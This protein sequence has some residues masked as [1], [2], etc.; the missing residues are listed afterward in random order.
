MNGVDAVVIGAGPNGLV[1]ANLLADAGWS[2]VVLEGQN[3]PGGSVRTAEVTAPGFRNDL[4][5]SFF[6]LSACPSPIAFLGLE[7]FGL[8]WLRSPT[9]LTHLTPDNASVT[10]AT[11]LAATE[12]SLDRFADGDGRRW[13][14]VVSAWSRIEPDFLRV[15]FTPFPP[16]RPAVRLVRTTGVGDAL[17]LARQMLLPAA[18]L[19]RQ[20]FAGQGA[21]L[22]V[23]GLALHTDVPPTSTASGGFGLLMAMLAQRYGFPVPE[24][25][26]GSLTRALVTRLRR[27]GGQV[28]CGAPVVH[29]DVRY[30]AARGVRTADGR[31]WVARRAVLADVPAPTLYHEL[32][33]GSA[34]P[35]RVLDDLAAFEYDLAT[36]KVDWALAG[37]IPW[38]AP[39]AAGSGTLHIGLDGDGMTRYAAALSS[40]RIPDEPLLICGQMTTADPTRSPAGTE[41]F[42][43]YTHL[44]HRRTWTPEEIADVVAGMERVLENAAPGFSSLVLARRVAGPVELEQENANLVGG[45]LAGGTNAVHQQL[46]FRPIPGLGRADTPVDRLYLA[47]AS[48]HPGGGVHGGP[49]A[50]AAKA[51]LSRDR[52]LSGPVYRTVVQSAQ[53]RLYRGQ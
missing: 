8:R 9:V 51:A 41:S 37:P 6:P 53:R 40:G 42:W 3:E 12:A 31:A 20:L 13:R 52:R 30:G 48:A 16:L 39:E 24:G 5:S 27:R 28:V 15:L 2:V 36:V 44:P 14:R 32:L 11:D 26:A 38:R 34:V 47:S 45:S 23:A 29:I 18:T 46:F 10:L 35:A 25:G 49:G 43:A 33:P 22:L 19:G 4:C 50:N 1:A 17:R 7:D 21:R